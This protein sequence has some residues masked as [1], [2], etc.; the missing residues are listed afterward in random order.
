MEIK[1]E[2]IFKEDSTSGKKCYIPYLNGIEL[3][4]V[5]SVVIKSNYAD[6]M[7]AEITVVIERNNDC[8]VKIESITP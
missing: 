7:T 8:I 2:L 6:V 5:A 1:R 4:F 3:P